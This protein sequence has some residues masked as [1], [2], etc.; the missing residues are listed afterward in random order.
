MLWLTANRLIN[1]A[2][3]YQTASAGTLHSWYISYNG[4]SFYWWWPRILLFYLFITYIVLICRSWLKAFC[5][6][7]LQFVTCLLCI[8][9][10]YYWLLHFFVRKY[11]L[12]NYCHL[13]W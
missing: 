2:V 4:N 10:Y 7:Y 12:R 5:Q 8:I 9:L 11:Q 1:I 6:P 13:L 3:I